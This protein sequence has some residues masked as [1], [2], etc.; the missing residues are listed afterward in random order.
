MSYLQRNLEQKTEYSLRY[1][2]IV[3]IL[4]PRQCGKST[5]ANEIIS[6]KKDKLILDLEKQSDLIQLQE[7]ELFLELHKNKL[8]C[9]DEIQRRA[10]LFPVLRAFVDEQKRNGILLILGSA[11]PDL[12]RQSS[13]SLA[14]RI[15]Y[16]ELSP[17]L[18]SELMA[19]DK[20]RG[21][22]IKKHWLRGGFPRAYLAENDELAFEWLNNFIR[23]FLE[24]DIPQLGF[25]LS[26]QTLYRF[27]RML[28]HLH[29]QSLNKSKLGDS[30]GLSHTTI[31]NYIDLLVNTFIIRL[32]EPYEANVKKRL[33][34]SPKMYFRD[35]GILHTLHS[36]YSYEDLFAHPVI[37]TS[38]EGYVI[39]NM[40]A[41]MPG[42]DATYY[43]TSRGSEIDLILKKSDRIIA[44][45]CKVSS[46]PGFTKE[47]WQALEDIN[48][49]KSFIIAPVKNPYYLKDS[50]MVCNPEYFLENKID[51]TDQK[52]VKNL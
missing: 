41:E 7:A 5:L 43:R 33:V 15:L 30:M 51:L 36:I 10:D 48:P 3:A 34:K 44:I 12:L 42:W 22:N 4:G 32:L 25:N 19:S 16:L 23:T 49:E 40:I 18:L 47:Y 27:W 35:S 37:G 38:W 31:R 20:I 29:G 46:A 52:K 21:F 8:I 24:R 17:F 13:E 11:S 14:G 28:S 50:V 9:L 1:Y 45:E 2:P 39:E 6:K 26:S